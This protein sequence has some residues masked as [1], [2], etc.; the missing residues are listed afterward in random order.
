[1]AVVLDDVEPDELVELGALLDAEADPVMLAE[2]LPAELLTVGEPL[3]LD[4]GALLVADIEVLVTGGTT[5]PRVKLDT[6]D[7]LPE[8]AG[9]LVCA[10]L[11]PAWE[12]GLPGT[13]GPDGSARPARSR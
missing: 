5:L 3:W 6:A 10:L 13:V 2:V 12:A 1:V 8:D 7:A 9:R 4:V 11:C